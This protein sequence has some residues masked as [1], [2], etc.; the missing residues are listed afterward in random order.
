[1]KVIVGEM[2]EIVRAEM[3]NCYQSLSK[4]S[5]NFTMGIIEYFFLFHFLLIDNLTSSAFSCLIPL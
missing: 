5:V 2:N 1:M 3:I 4:Y